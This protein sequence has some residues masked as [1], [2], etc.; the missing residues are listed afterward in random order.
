[1]SKY[2]P[3][4]KYVTCHSEDSVLKKIVLKL[5]EPP[6]IELIDGYGLPPIENKL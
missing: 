1:M 2:A 6:P 3:A 4:D 5:P